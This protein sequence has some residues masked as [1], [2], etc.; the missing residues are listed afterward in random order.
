VGSY[1]IVSNNNLPAFLFVRREAMILN[2]IHKAI[3]LDIKSFFSFNDGTFS[4]QPV[5]LY[6]EEVTSW[7]NI[8][9]C[10]CLA[11]NGTI[12]VLLGA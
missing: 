10:A 3:F 11:P 8:S 1:L 2:Q 4:L 6:S 9:K 7:E 5:N 12:I